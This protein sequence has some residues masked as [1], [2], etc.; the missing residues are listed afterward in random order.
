MGSLGA[1]LRQDRTRLLIAALATA[2]VLLLGTQSSMP[3]TML[4]MEWLV[5]D[6][7]AG[8][9]RAPLA[10]DQTVAIVDIDEASIDAIAGWP[11]P[12]EIVAHL[13]RTLLEQ[14]D[15]R[16]VA[17][18]I[19]F[20]EAVDIAGDKQLAKL[21][22][23]KPVI[24]A[25]VFDMSGRD[26][27]PKVGQP[28]GAWLAKQTNQTQSQATSSLTHYSVPTADGHIANHSGLSNAVCVGH[29]SP[30]PDFD[31]QV[32]RIAP[33]VQYKQHTYPMLALAVLGCGKSLTERNALLQASDALTRDAYMRIPYRTGL[34]GYTVIPAA[35]IVSGRAPKELLAQRHV[36]VG[37]SAL[38]LGDR[39]ATP[40]HPWLPGVVLH[41]ELLSALM[42]EQQHPMQRQDY[43]WVS[44]VWALGSIAVLAIAFARARARTALILLAL[45][46]LAWLALVDY[47]LAHEHTI[48]VS[49]PLVPLA[50]FLFVQAPLEWMHT[51]TAARSF[52]A[53][54]RKYLP[55]VVLDQLV[56]ES[57]D[58]AALKP[59]RH[60]I[61]VLFVDVRGYTATAETMQPE[62]L[63]DFT[64]MILSALTTEVQKQDGTLDKY[65]GDALMAFWGAPLPQQDHAERALKA[66]IGMLQAV[67][68]IN[69]TLPHRY[70]DLPPIEIRIGIASGEA[71]VGELGTPQRRSYTAIGDA[72]NLAS[73]LQD[74]A[75]TTTHHLLLSEATAHLLQGFTLQALPAVTIRGR[76]RA[77]AV[78]ALLGA[79]A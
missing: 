67:S 5:H 17:L 37:S 1:V 32:R 73:R 19:V 24:L 14:Y 23:T 13:V 72:V 66:G 74:H 71:V 48:N 20:P 35:D 49:L 15:A 9:R 56:R 44:W 43:R 26:D 39:V 75:K 78:Y 11:W 68:D 6:W 10:Q 18:D 59:A 16:T 4:R 22:E 79:P 3:R 45:I 21:A 40:I 63:A 27:A 34:Q 51:Q 58:Q 61:S 8:M 76:S 7:H 77:E 62:R 57:R 30:Q 70:P 54:M 12:R 69:S 29:I 55:P 42:Q 50:I 33:L 25:Q 41:A 28:A 65:M 31:G 53:R 64:Q 47:L 36:L 60:V 2:L 38:G 52:A 46:A